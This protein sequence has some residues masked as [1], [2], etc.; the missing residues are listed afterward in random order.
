MTNAHSKSD[1]SWFGLKDV[2]AGWLT[3]YFQ[4]KALT[5]QIIWSKAFFSNAEDNVKSG[6]LSIYEH[7]V[8]WDENNIDAHM[9]R[10]IFTQRQKALLQDDGY[11]KLWNRY[12]SREFTYAR[13]TDDKSSPK[14]LADDLYENGAVILA[15]GV[16]ASTVIAGSVL[17]IPKFAI[18]FVDRQRIRHAH[19][20]L[21]DKLEA[22][23]HS[24]SAS[25]SPKMK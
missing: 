21:E 9:A 16:V 22:Q 14:K 13:W 12:A 11:R 18:N 20:S 23:N 3:K 7:S 10:G 6:D 2:A 5:A 24:A 1:S 17:D 8:F 25:Q 15:F 4:S 19:N